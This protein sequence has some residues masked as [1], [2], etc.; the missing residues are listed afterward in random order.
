MLRDWELQTLQKSNGSILLGCSQLQAGASIPPTAM[1]QPF[2]PRLLPLRLPRFS[3]PPLLS[4]F[5]GV[6]SGG[7]TPGKI[8]GITDARRRVL[9]HFGHKNQHL[10]EPGFLTGS[11]KFRISSKCACSMWIDE[12]LYVIIW[13]KYPLSVGLS[14]HAS[15]ISS[16][17]VAIALHY[18][19]FEAIFSSPPPEISMMQRASFAP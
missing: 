18:T 11:C 4:P 14:Q 12:V 13:Q 5:T 10:Y 9:E 7:M 19:E 6:R 17:I 3:S 1:T 8:F 15:A 2:P 16:L